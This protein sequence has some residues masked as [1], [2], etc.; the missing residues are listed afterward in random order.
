MGG[1]TREGIVC[2]AESQCLTETD[3]FTNLYCYDRKC[4]DRAQLAHTTA[5]AETSVGSARHF[6]VPARGGGAATLLCAALAGT[7]LSCFALSLGWTPRLPGRHQFRPVSHIE[8]MQTGPAPNRSDPHPLARL[9]IQPHRSV[10]SVARSH[11]THRARRQQQDV[12]EQERRQQEDR[13]RQMDFEA[14]QQDCWQ[15]LPFATVEEA[16]E[17]FAAAI[18]ARKQHRVR[19]HG[20]RRRQ[21]RRSVIGEDACRR[22]LFHAARGRATRHR[23]C[24]RHWAAAR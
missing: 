3:Y 18:A 9:H 15:Q 12:Q 23:S 13:M 8:L 14:E 1:G 24:L 5:R 2:D 11:P 22:D 21:A 16:E 4:H 20:A 10:L 7:M 17:Y 6:V 19:V